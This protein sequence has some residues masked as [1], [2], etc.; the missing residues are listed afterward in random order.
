MIRPK[1]CNF[2]KKNSLF[3][4]IDDFFCLDSLKFSGKLCTIFLFF[5][6][7]LFSDTVKNEFG[8][9]EIEIIETKPL[10]S[11]NFVQKQTNGGLQDYFR[12]PN[13]EI[14]T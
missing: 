2:T 13:Y 5:T 7:I 14:G 9:E 6:V 8:D 10:E 11:K 3:I 4:W 1:N 12:E